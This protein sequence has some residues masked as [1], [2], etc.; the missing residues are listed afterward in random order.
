VARSTQA[1]TVHIP[2]TFRSRPMYGRWKRRRIS[3][4]RQF[5]GWSRQEYGDAAPI[6]SR[7][8]ILKSLAL[9]MSL[10]HPSQQQW[11]MLAV[12]GTVALYVQ[13][14]VQSEAVQ[15]ATYFWIHAGPIVAHYK[16]AKWWLTKTKAS[17]QKRNRVYQRLHNQYSGKSFEIAL[18]LKGLYVKVSSGLHQQAHNN[19][20]S[21]YDLVF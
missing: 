3:K 15:R 6:G 2:G 12:G 17:L 8:E 18:K 20:L 5:Y 16:F 10:K 21:L 14:I 7:G 1:S 19:S 9:A 13:R 4:Q 11:I